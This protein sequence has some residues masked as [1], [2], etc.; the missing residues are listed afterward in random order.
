MTDTSAGSQQ[1][2]SWITQQVQKGPGAS[3][4]TIKVNPQ[5]ASNITKRLTPYQNFP[6]K[7]AP[8]L[9]GMA[10]Y[11]TGTII[12]RI[13]KE[14]GPGWMKLSQR[15][16]S[17]RKRAGF[18]PDHPILIRTG[19]LYKELTSK[20]HPNHVEVITTGK[21]ARIRIGG[22]S[23]KFVRNQGGDKFLNIPSRPMLPGTGGA[24]LDP[25][26]QIR[27]QEILATSIKQQMQ[28]EQGM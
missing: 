5:Y 6:A 26:D 10:D 12:P 25:N 27:L 2:I 7:F 14:E 17:E 3:T 8:A 13:F 22:S 18:P 21:N 16:Q 23:Q 11:I 15:T 4:I 28:Q 19:D 1:A 20:S 24:P 9:E